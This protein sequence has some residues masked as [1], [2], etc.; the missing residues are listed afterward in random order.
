MNFDNPES[1]KPTS[2]EDFVGNA[3]KWGRMLMGISERALSK[4]SSPPIKLLMYGPPG[5]GKTELAHL[6]AMH[7]AKSAENVE[8]VSCRKLDA[9]AVARYQKQFG[10]GSI[11]GDWLALILDEA[12]TCPRDGQDALLTFLDKMPP[13]RLVIATSNCELDDLTERFQTRFRHLEFEAAPESEIANLLMKFD[14]MSRSDA[15]EIAANANGNVRAA[16]LDAQTHLDYQLF[17]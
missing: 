6:I 16:L 2:V 1:W 17:A 3:S 13:N 8:I 9:S 12:D 10:C 15:E 14:G 11:F 7:L 4:K 5:V